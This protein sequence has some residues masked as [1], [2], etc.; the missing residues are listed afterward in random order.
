[1]THE[2][3]WDRFKD[4]LGNFIDTGENLGMSQDHLSNIG[5]HVGN[6]LNANVDAHNREERV[7]KDLWDAGDDED[8]KA[9][10]KMIVKMVEKR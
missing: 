9:L 7:I 2:S 4:T 6:V 3:V 5:F 8:R 10:S 1:M